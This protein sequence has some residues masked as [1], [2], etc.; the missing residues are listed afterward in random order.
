MSDFGDSYLPWV[1]LYLRVV[2]LC[3]LHHHDIQGRQ[4]LPLKQLLMSGQIDYQLEAFA[5]LTE[6]NGPIYSIH[7][8]AYN[9]M[10]LRFQVK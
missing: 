4:I 7:M 6:E 1:M 8:A 3:Y 9:C 5:A 10:Q 2:L